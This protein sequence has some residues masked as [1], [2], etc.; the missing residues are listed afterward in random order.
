MKLNK[1]VM[2]FGLNLLRIGAFFES[3]NEPSNSIHREEF[4]E[5]LRH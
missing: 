2:K 1:C 4:I 5:E 3:G